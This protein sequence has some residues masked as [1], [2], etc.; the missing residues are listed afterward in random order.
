MDKIKIGFQ[1]APQHGEYDVLRQ[2][3]REA[4]QLGVD[5]LYASD[6]FFAQKVPLQFGSGERHEYPAANNGP[7]FEAMTIQTAMAALTTKPTIGCLVHANSYRN[8]NLLADM[9]RT[10][11][12]ISGGR[13]V[14]G[15]G[16]GY[17]EQDYLEYGYE[18]GTPKSR[19]QD[20]ARALPIIRDRFTKLIP[21]PVH[22]IPILIAAMGEKWGL[23]IVAE[24]ADMWHVFGPPEKLAHK[25]GL[26]KE[27]CAKIGRNFDEIELT[28]WY[29]PH[30]LQQEQD[31][32]DFV[33]L[34]IRNIINVQQGP[35][36]DLGLVKDLL[37]WRARRSESIAT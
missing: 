19:Y 26:L 5:G 4:E 24:H 29:F 8:P 6:H 1:P 16:T 20:L 27:I 21:P 2:R 15:I 37:A 12:H 17:L 28:T 30:M 32:E 9:A 11:D 33:K 7:N 3:W 36:W 13:F 14:L 18:L 23:P 22:R 10:I 34:G 35:D 31:P 25:I